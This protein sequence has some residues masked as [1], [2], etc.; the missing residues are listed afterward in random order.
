MS[1]KVTLRCLSLLQPYASLVVSGVKTLETRTGPVLSRHRGPLLIAAS[2]GKGG[3]LDAFARFCSDWS[4]PEGWE[5]YPRGVILGV[6]NVR[7]V[8]R[9]WDAGV[10]WVDSITSRRIPELQRRPISEL[11]EEYTPGAPEP[12]PYQHIR[13]AACFGQIERRWLAVLDRAAWLDC[14]RPPEVR[15]YPGLYKAEVAVDALPAWAR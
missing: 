14:P 4:T 3:A 11:L 7:D 6:V 9:P 13:R 15:G 5:R 1:E 8:G 12:D 10:L 2:K